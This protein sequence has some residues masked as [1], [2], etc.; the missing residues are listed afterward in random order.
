VYYQIMFGDGIGSYKGLPDITG[1][2]REEADTLPI[3]GWMIGW[4]HEWNERWTSNFTYSEN[5]IDNRPFQ[6]PDDLHLNTYF[7][8]NLIWNPA[9]RVYCGIEYLFGTRENFDDSRGEANRLQMS[10][11]FELP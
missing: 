11:I 2:S 7:A 6:A 3:F 10:F 4:T 9:R 5:R 8:I 1:I